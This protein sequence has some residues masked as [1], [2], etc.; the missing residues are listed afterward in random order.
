LSRTEEAY[1]FWSPDGKFIAYETEHQLF[2]ISAAGGPAQ[3][4]CSARYPS[5]GT[6][7]KDGVIVFG[8]WETPLYKVSAT[9]GNP[10][11]LD[12]FD[13]S[14]H[15]TGHLWPSFL[16][17]SR[18]Y[19]YLGIATLAADYTLRIGSLDS[20]DSIILF[21][22]IFSPAIYDSGKI[23]FVRDGN[24]MSQ[25]FDAA[26][27]KLT[28]EAVPV[29]AHLA[30]HDRHY[31]PFSANGAMLVFLQ[32]DSTGRL[33]WFDRTGKMLG[34]VGSPADDVGAELSPDDQTVAFERLDVNRRNPEIWLLDLQRGA[35]SQFTIN[36]M[37]DVFPVWSPDGKTIAYGS[38]VDGK[39]GIYRAPAIG[40]ARELILQSEGDPQS[41]GQ[42]GISLEINNEK[43]GSAD[44]AVLPLSGDHK[45]IPIAET[46]AWEWRSQFSLDGHWIAYNSGSEVFVQPF[47][48]TGARW[49]VSSNGGGEVRWRA[50]G[51]ELYFV[52]N[53]RRQLMAVE[54]QTENS[55]RAGIPKP[56]FTADFRDFQNRFSY[57][58]TRDGQRFLVNTEEPETAVLS[59]I[60]NWLDS[61]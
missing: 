3:V 53:D 38:L 58:V 6:W 1:P 43:L 61:L 51:R 47:P 33:K 23:L 12:T 46:A 49:Q 15:E 13:A 56:L 22:H 4:L 41:W 9:G 19:L 54:V 55:F 48:P 25:P 34:E 31:Y 14:H 2:K 28:G 26:K 37:G 59:V 42:P 30:W 29:A 17:D 11:Q 5:G 7:N 45:L 40:G 16:P 18:H 20:K 52:G 39:V 44:I 8:S 50:D 60:V 24:L 32:H 10:V 57:D 35:E 36:P 21:D 27:L